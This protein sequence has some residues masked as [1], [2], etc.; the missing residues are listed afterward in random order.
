MPYMVE[1]FEVVLSTSNGEPLEGRC[2]FTVT[3]SP[4]EFLTGPRAIGMEA[5]KKSK[6]RR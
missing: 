1:L 4:V 3:I 5:E 2:Y 6:G